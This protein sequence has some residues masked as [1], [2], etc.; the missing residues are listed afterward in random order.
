MND[1]YFSLCTLQQVSGY[2]GDNKSQRDRCGVFCGCNVGIE[3]ISLQDDN[4]GHKETDWIDAGQNRT[5]VTA[6]TQRGLNRER[7]RR[8]RRCVFKKEV[9]SEVYEL[10]CKGEIKCHKREVGA[11]Q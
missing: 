8:S 2:R 7:L 5:A 10:I 1:W 11:E 3:M 9:S 6:Q 4:P